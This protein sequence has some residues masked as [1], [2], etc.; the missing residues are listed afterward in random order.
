M[1]ERLALD[2]HV[3]QRP[4]RA[5]DW[6]IPQDAVVFRPGLIIRDH[7]PFARLLGGVGHALAVGAEVGD[8]PSFSGFG[9]SMGLS[10][11][12]GLDVGA[13]WGKLVAMP[14]SCG[15][16]SEVAS[17]AISGMAA[18]RTAA[19]TALGNVLRFIAFSNL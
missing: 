19:G 4:V 17:R 8:T 10:F 1:E 11:M 14:G 16:A 15:T 7:D 6:A 2:G 3:L 18:A 12:A 9:R 5:E 13:L